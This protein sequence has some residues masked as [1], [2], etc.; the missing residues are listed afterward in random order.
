MERET[1][2]ATK[3]EWRYR[4]GTWTVAQRESCRGG[5]ARSAPLTLCL[6]AEELLPAIN[7]AVHGKESVIEVPVI[8]SELLGWDSFVQLRT[9]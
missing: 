9:S 5:I 7:L 2:K 4:Y 3:W 6:A 1:K 8:R